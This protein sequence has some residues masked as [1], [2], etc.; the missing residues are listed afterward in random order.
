[1]N[2]AG[3]ALRYQPRINI[4]II[5]EDRG[6][7]KFNGPPVT[8]RLPHG[9]KLFGWPVCSNKRAQQNQQSSLELPSVTGSSLA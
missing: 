8:C 6:K 7:K 9:R 3:P 2:E 1:L 4:I 5:S